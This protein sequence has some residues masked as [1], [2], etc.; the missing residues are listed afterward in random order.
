MN[1]EVQKY[2][3]QKHSKSRFGKYLFDTMFTNLIGNIYIFLLFP[4]L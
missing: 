3:K 2:S 1:A 4:S